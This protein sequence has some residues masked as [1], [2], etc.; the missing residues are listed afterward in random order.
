MVNRIIVSMMCSVC[1]NKNYFFSTS[2]KYEKKLL[3]KKFCKNCSKHT[4]HEQKK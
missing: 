4:N 3:L 2:K 1:K